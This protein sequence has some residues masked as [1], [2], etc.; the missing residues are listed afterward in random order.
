MYKKEK[1]YLLVIFEKLL[2]SNKKSFN[3]KNCKKSLFF[4]KSLIQ[5]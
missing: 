5:Q 2:F 3:I 4:K 1:K